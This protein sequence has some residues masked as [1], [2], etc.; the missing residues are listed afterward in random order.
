MRLYHP[1]HK[2]GVV[3]NLNDGK[4]SLLLEKVRL[5]LV[6]TMSWDTSVWSN[7]CS[8]FLKFNVRFQDVCDVVELWNLQKNLCSS[9][10]LI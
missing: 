10:V 6:L 7:L 3:S 2:A 1:A 5:S 9:N 4:K 8:N